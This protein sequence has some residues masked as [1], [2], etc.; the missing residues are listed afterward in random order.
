MPTLVEMVGDMQK[1]ILDSLELDA[2]KRAIVEKAL[3]ELWA[4]KQL[5]ANAAAILEKQL[6][7]DVLD[8][9]IRQ[10]TPEVQAMVRAGISDA[11]PE[12][13]KAWLDAAKKQPDAKERDALARRI[14]V[15][16]PRPGPLKELLLQVGEV[17]A[18]VAQVASGSDELRA[19]LHKTLSEG[20]APMM[21]AMEVKETMIAGTIIAY[22]DQP[23]AKMRFLADAL[24]S[25]SGRQL[26]SAALASLLGGAKQTREQLVARL[27]AELKP[28]TKKKK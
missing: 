14:S 5:Y 1:D 4:E 26:Q 13:A 9:A 27:Q 17:M 11:S 7:P 28:A 19:A 25:A 10:M 15:H 23:T 16:L 21:A 8:A 18:D 24:D 3:T 12:Q 2:K 22:R 20:V 6:A